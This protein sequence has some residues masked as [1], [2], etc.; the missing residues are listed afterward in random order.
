MSEFNYDSNYAW[1]IVSD[2]FNKGFLVGCD[3][4]QNPPYGL[5]WGHAYSVVSVHTLKDSYGNVQYRLLRI[6]NPWGVDI[7][8]G[9]W[10][11]GDSRWTTAYKS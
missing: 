10:N 8:S 5:V 11:D 6:R 4:Y 3:T 7:Y 2:A 1:N 9:P